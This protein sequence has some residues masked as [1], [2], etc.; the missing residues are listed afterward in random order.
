MYLYIKDYH[1]HEMGFEFF[2]KKKKRKR[3]K[4][5]KIKIKMKIKEDLFLKKERKKERK[6]ERKM[7]SNQSPR[8]HNHTRFIQYGTILLLVV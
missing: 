8:C 4:G 2:F 7:R 5:E 3:K 6:A 1:R